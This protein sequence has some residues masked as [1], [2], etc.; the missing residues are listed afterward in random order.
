MTP[1]L[2]L[3]HGNCPD[4]FAAAWAL[5]KKFPQAA[6]VPV[7]HGQP[8]PLDCSGRRV[9]IVDFSYPR[10]V[11][12]G[13]AKAA[14]EMQVLDHHVTAQSQLAGLPYVKFDLNKSGA[15]LAWEWAHGTPPPWLL[16]YV[17]DKDL[18]AW[19]L[20]KSRE[21]TAALGSY[22]YDFVTWNS[23]KQE[24][25]EQE[26]GAILRYEQKLI[27][28]ILQ[29]VVM[30]QFEGQTVP[31]VNSSILTSQIGEH[32]TNTYEFCLIWH[33]KHGRRYF[34]LRS[35]E[36]ATDVSRIA[37]RYGG[38]GHKHAAGFSVPLDGAGSPPANGSTQGVALLPAVPEQSSR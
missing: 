9:V 13:M 2:I 29:D 35:R 22:R 36:G 12:E 1:D 6:Y 10:P 17:Q 37:V 33:D 27:E 24:V 3:Y 28:Q 34:S 23:L 26:G 19:K 5:W 32:L 4:G 20:P 15:V 30:V 7:E 25:L 8:P 21:I 31:C 14:A 11:L 38:G 16:L 18:F